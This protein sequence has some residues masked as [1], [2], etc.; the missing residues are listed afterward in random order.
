MRADVPA[1]RQSAVHVE[2]SQP[3]D[4]AHMQCDEDRRADSRHDPSQRVVDAPAA[5]S[6]R[7]SC[8]VA[9]SVSCL[10]NRGPARQS[11]QPE[12]SRR[13]SIHCAAM[14]VERLCPKVVAR[15]KVV[16]SW[17]SNCH[18]PTLQQHPCAAV[19]VEEL[20]PKVAARVEVDN[21]VSDQLERV[22]VP[23]APLRRRSRRTTP[24]K[25]APRRSSSTSWPPFASRNSHRE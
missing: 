21:V 11:P 10:P 7:R 13:S 5:H 19:H 23:A 9:P 20:R 15:V 8:R 14:H 6:R 1:A 25:P 22:G 17:P 4:V 12:T 24:Q 2:V 16:P 3:E 18:L